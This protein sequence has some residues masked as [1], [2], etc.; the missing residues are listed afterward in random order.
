MDRTSDNVNIHIITDPPMI[1]TILIIGSGSFVGGVARFL[2]TKAVQDNVTGSFPWGT[3]AVNAA[4]C[5]A[6]GLIYGL[7]ERGSLMSDSLRLFLT[8]GFCGGFTTYSTFMHDNWSLLG[9][10]NFAASAGYT[11]L[12]LAL[13]LG[14]ACLGHLAARLF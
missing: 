3:L 11:F 4:G 14:A 2:L 9:V 13:G 6:I 1:K 7:L 12:S 5:L 8:V 10:G